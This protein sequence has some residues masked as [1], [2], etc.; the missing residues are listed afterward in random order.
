VCMPSRGSSSWLQPTVRWT[1]A[2]CPG[3]HLVWSQH[4][5]ACG[6]RQPFAA[7]SPRCSDNSAPCLRRFPRLDLAC[8]ARD[9]SLRQTLSMLSCALQTALACALKMYVAWSW[10]SLTNLQHWLPSTSGYVATLWSLTILFPSPPAGHIRRGRAALQ[11]S[12]SRSNPAA[13]ALMLTFD[14][15]SQTLCA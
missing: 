7:Q 8:L 13:R 11:K 2:S 10:A 14:A 5:S 12:S 15:H 1:K 4:K 6:S 9:H 3:R